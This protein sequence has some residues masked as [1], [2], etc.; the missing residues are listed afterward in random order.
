MC[1]HLKSQDTLYF[2]GDLQIIDA[3]SIPLTLQIVMSD[4]TTKL[5]FG[6]PSQVTELFPAT[7]TKFT[8]DSVKFNVSNIGI[9]C[10]LRYLND[11]QTL[12]GTFKQGLLNQNITFYKTNKL[13]SFHRPQ[14]P[15]RPFIYNEKELKFENPNCKYLF[16]GTLTYP[17][18]EGKYPLVVLVSGS[19]CQNRDEELFAHKPFMI[20]ADY[21]TK[22]GIAVFRYDDRGFGSTD[23]NMY[24]GTTKDFAMDTRCAIQMLKKQ[25]CIDPNNIFV[26]GHSEGGMICQVLGKE[27]KDLRGLIL[28][29]APF[30][31]GKKILASQTETILRLNH[32]DTHDIETALNDIENAKYDTT[33]ISGLWLNYFYHFEPSM[34]VSKI[35]TP[36]LIL[37]G[38]MDMQVLAD[39]N[40]S[41]LQKTI[42]Q[43]TH[44]FTIRQYPDLNH[45][46]QHCNTGN[47]NEY[48]Q[49]EETISE[50]VLKDIKDFILEYSVR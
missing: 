6:S 48:M 39:I 13:F 47:P 26:L 45:L 16:H 25:D 31:S 30:V 29:A 27:G 8:N 20:I 1:F 35:K 37:Q 5:F 50:Q 19:G 9:K 42:S 14:T 23:T 12:K 24:K 46:F 17:K 22:N 28:M 21:L 36:M 32:A 43:R 33:T 10:R 41:A 7:K 4:D 15:Q 3:Q 38:G 44:N 2:K 18:K 40:L 11:K 49:I 34:Y